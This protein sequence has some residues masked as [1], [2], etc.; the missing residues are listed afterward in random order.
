MVLL[1]N[2]P[3][4]YTAITKHHPSCAKTLIHHHH[5]NP[6]RCLQPTTTPATSYAMST[7]NLADTPTTSEANAATLRGITAALV[8]LVSKVDNSSA[9]LTEIDDVITTIRADLSTEVTTIRV[10]QGRLHAAVNNVQ[11]KQL[12]VGDKMPLEPQPS[13]PT[14]NLP[15]ILL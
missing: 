1:T 14:N 6:S 2:P 15:Q 9:L 13:E 12:V 4:S 7:S 10:H 5:R 8:D 3:S 11:P